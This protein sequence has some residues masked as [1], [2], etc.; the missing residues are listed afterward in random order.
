[1]QELNLTQ[2]AV[3]HRIKNL[4]KQLGFPLFVRLTR[5]MEL[6]PEGERLLVTLNQSFDSIF[7]ELEDI[8][9]NELS[10]ELY[11]GTSP[12]FANG[13]LMPRLGAF[14]QQ[15]PNLNVRLL[16]K[17]DKIDFQ[18]EPLDAAIY[19]SDDDYPG[20]YCY[21]LFDER[22]IPVCSPEYAKRLGLAEGKMDGLRD[23]TFIHGSRSSIWQRWL[24]EM[25][26]TDIDPTKR[27]YIFNFSDF[28]VNAARQS[29]GIAMGRQRFAMPFILSGELVAPFPS[30]NTGLGYDLVCPDGMQKR[31]KFQAFYRWLKQEL[32]QENGF[33][34]GSADINMSKC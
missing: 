14:Q 29:L 20:F 32:E 16:A 7:T 24:K 28:D 13:W 31:P 21:R 11:I 8:R 19:Y 25:G 3:S 27:Q 2:G 5:R 17:E 12:G 18:Y 1:A 33:D 9:T 23:A 34:L 30:I 26:V 10:G 22:R 6:T 15:F 4:E